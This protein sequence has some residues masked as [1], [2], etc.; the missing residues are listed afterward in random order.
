M[1]LEININQFLF[2]I[3]RDLQIKGVEGNRRFSLQ[4]AVGSLKEGPHLGKELAYG[5]CFWFLLLLDI[6]EKVLHK[7]E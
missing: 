2:H 7:K 3:R 1:S 4:N 6:F 5:I